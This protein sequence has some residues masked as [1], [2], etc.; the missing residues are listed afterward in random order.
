[1]RSSLEIHSLETGRSRVAYQTRDLI[2]APNWSR[3]GAAL[4][5]NGA[6]LIYRIGLSEPASPERIDTGFAVNCNN[7]H[8]LSPD[9]KLLAISDQSMTGDSTVYVLDAAGGAPRQVTGHNPSYWHGWSPDGGTLAFVGKRGG[10]FDIYTIGVDGGE[11]RR[12]TDGTGHN[13][14]PDYSPDGKWIYFNSSRIARNQI[15]R[16]HPDGTGLERLTDD[17]HAD[18]FPHPSPDGRHVVFV[19]FSGDT[20]GHPR[21]RQVGMRMMNSD[22]SGLRTLF[23]LFGGQGSINVPSWSPDS[24][25]FAYVRYF[26]E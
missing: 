16:M 8:G 17:G 21:D 2:E 22:G 24:R 3:D 12:L 9:N 11:E 13:D 1:M 14:G 4:I 6:G 5:F 26:P 7:D 15:W 23:D 10:V 18:W 19:S 20:E 25:E